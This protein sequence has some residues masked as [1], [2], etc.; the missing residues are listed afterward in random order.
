MPLRDLLDT[1]RAT[2][3]C[4]FASSIGGGFLAVMALQIIER[5]P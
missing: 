4:L 1:A 2:A 5:I 3:L